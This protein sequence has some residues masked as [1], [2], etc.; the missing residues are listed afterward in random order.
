MLVINIPKRTLTFKSGLTD[1]EKY[2]ITLKVWW[3][4]AP[5]IY[6]E[7]PVCITDYHKKLIPIPDKITF[8]QDLN[9]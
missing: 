9:Y 5:L 4:Y 6:Y 8:D 7:I 3:A 1:N 2:Y